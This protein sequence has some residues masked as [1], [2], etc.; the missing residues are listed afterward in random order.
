MKVKNQIYFHLMNMFSNINCRRK[1][2]RKTLVW[3][4]CVSGQL[5]SVQ[6]GKPNYPHKTNIMTNLNSIPF[7]NGVLN[8]VNHQ[9]VELFHCLAS[10]YG[11]LECSSNSR[12]LHE[13]PIVIVFSD[14]DMILNCCLFLTNEHIPSL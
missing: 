3:S 2:L 1:Y 6:S 9:G 5:L 11:S 10:H 13:N 4:C 12:K 14:G 7:C 8:T